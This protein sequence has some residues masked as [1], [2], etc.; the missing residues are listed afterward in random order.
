VRSPAYLFPFFPSPTSTAQPSSP[1]SP[2]PKEAQPTQHGRRPRPIPL[3]PPRHQ[4]TRDPS[5]SL[6]PGAADRRDPPVSFPFFLCPL[7]LPAHSAPR[8]HSPRSATTSATACAPLFHLALSAARAHEALAPGI[9][10][11]A[12]PLN[13]RR[14][15]FS[16][17]PSPHQRKRGERRRTRTRARRRAL[18]PP[19]EHLHQ[20]GAPY[21]DTDEAARP[22]Q[23][24]PTCADPPLHRTPSP[25]SPR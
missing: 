15:A 20:A 9:R 14:P 22:A 16:L 11:L 6:P 24:R 7:P 8:R 3:P 17:P 13:P 4:L 5:P 18:P 21:D 23:L 1:L 19:P 12:A 2:F 10:V 25:A